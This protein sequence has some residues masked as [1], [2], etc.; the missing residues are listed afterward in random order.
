MSLPLQSI[1]RTLAMEQIDGWLLYD[2][3]G[4]NPIAVKLAG[5]GRGKMTTRR[6]FYFIPAAGTPKKLVHAIEP[7]VLDGLPGDRVMYAG[8]R[9]FE[10]QATDMLRGCK[11]LAMEYSAECGIPYLSGVVAGTVDFLRSIGMRG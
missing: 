2:F 8:R 6:W 1:Q 5:L 4:S 3:H 7:D 10:Q 11:V 9:Q